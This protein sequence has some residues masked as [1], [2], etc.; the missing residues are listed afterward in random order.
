MEMQ[1]H[2]ISSLFDQLGLDDSEDAI[3]AFIARHQPVPGNLALHQAAFWSPAQAAF[4][5]QAIA[6]DAD[7]ADA[8]DRLDAQLRKRY[9]PQG[10]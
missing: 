3:A 10:N 4:L 8:V 1:T 9:R 6:E 2:S 7:W 5:Q